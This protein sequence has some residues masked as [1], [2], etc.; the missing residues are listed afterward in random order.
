MS[1]RGWSVMLFAAVGLL[2]CGQAPSAQRRPDFSGT[3]VFLEAEATVTRSGGR[4]PVRVL[5]VS[6]AAFN[7]GA[8]CT[9][10]QNARTLTV[11][12]PAP[13]NAPQRPDVVLNLNTGGAQWEGNNLVVT[14]SMG[15]LQIRQVIALEKDRLIVTS[16]IVTT[17]V[18]DAPVRQTYV[19][20]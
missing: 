8:Q 3:W 20:K 16:L 13:E 1:V 11:S 6:G 10:V 18:D 5:E 14:Q 9:I 15:V 2:L 7:C 4:G 19:R 12:R 17:S